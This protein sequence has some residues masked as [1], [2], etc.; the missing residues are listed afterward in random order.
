[1]PVNKQGITKQKKQGHLSVFSKQKITQSLRKQT[2][3]YQKGSC[4]QCKGK[5][6]EFNSY[7]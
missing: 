6:I 7:G 1:V 3:Y 4:K 2:L 5:R